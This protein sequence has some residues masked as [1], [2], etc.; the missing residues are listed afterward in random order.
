MFD[1]GMGITVKK[2]I[3]DT[4]DSVASFQLALGTH[5]SAWVPVFSVQLV[6]RRM[7]SLSFTGYLSFTSSMPIAPRL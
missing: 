1:N 3:K 6:Y 5:A 4:A 2:V 7:S